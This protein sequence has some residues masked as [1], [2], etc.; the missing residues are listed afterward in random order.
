VRRRAFTLLEAILALG[1]LSAAVIVCV[2]VRGQVIL[3]A[4]RLREVQRQ[5]RADDGLFQMLINQT[6]DE[7]SVDD[8]LGTLVWRGTYLG[9]PYE[10]E[11][12]GVSF[13]NPMA[14]Q[15]RYDV[16]DRVRL[17]RYAIT[18]DGRES[19]VLWHR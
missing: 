17:V 6:I 18:Y 10:I 16:S 5:D 19:E 4:Q 3:G 7:P 15:V 1:I 2:G 13:P 12:R 9:T 11:R 8:R 14:G